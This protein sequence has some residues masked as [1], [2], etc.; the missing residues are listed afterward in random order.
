MTGERG[1]SDDRA[2]GEPRRL[3]PLGIALHS[4]NSAPQLVVPALA[5][6]WSMRDS[7]V[8]VSLFLLLLAGIS[9]II[10]AARWSTFRYTIDRDEIRIEQGILHRQTRAISFDR[11]VDVGI[12]QQ[13]VARIVG[14]AEVTFDS[15]GGAG[16]EARLRYV[17][18]DDAQALRE[19]VRGRA[20]TS[21]ADAARAE[22]AAARPLFAMGPRRLV[23]MGF[24]SFSLVVFAIAI[25]AARRLDFLLPDAWFDPDYWWSTVEQGG[26]RLGG[27]GLWIEFLAG[28]AALAALGAL[29]VLSGIVRA[30]TAWWDFRL[31]RTAKGLRIRYGLL[32]RHDVTVPPGRVLAAAI[33]TGPIRA[34]RGWQAL[35]LVSL[36]GNGESGAH[37]T[38][39]PFARNDE[40]AGIM[41]ELRLVP[42]APSLA[43]ARAS[44]GIALDRWLLSSALLGLAA[45]A[46]WPWFPLLTF[47]APAG[48]ALLGLRTWLRWRSRAR[49]V[50]DGQLFTRM[51]W[52]RRQILFARIDAAQAVT[53]MTGPLQ[54]RRGVTTLVFGL[55]GVTAA[56]KDIPRSEAEAIRAAVLRRIVPVDYT[57]LAALLAGPEK[58]AEA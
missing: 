3:S 22:P 43:F 5:G 29:G 10:A 19:C 45:G 35:Q 54:R 23:T 15:G 32:T 40:I 11:I 33:Q 2:T 9:V 41:A 34:R 47:A 25:A 36:G 57:L 24:Y 52:W 30:F 31:E 56:F 55:P 18:L 37:I 38:A 53:L 16:E 50:A 8:G 21:G 46:V 7:A 42:P 4:L 28:L 49:A 39:A 17:T 14:L 6:L 27:M 51:G 48:I 20:A 13:A 44:G 1:P 12:E 26:T 58:R